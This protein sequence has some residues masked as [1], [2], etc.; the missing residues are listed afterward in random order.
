MSELTKEDVLEA[1]H[2]NK[3]KKHWY[4]FEYYKHSFFQRAYPSEFIAKQIRKKLGISYT[5]S[6]VNIVFHRYKKLIASPG[7]SSSV[8]PPSNTDPQPIKPAKDDPET[9]LVKYQFTNA[10]D[11]PLDPDPNDFMVQYKARQKYFEELEKKKA[12]DDSSKKDQ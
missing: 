3:R 2:N 8:P 9:E 1:W 4:I 11:L 6:Q 12:Q 5:D 7:Q 10:S